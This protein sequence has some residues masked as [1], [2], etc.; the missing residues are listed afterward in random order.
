MVHDN[1]SNDDNQK[2]LARQL[3]HHQAHLLTRPLDE[4][5][6]I[7]LGCDEK[8]FVLSRY[9]GGYCVN[10]RQTQLFDQQTKEQTL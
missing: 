5:G 9:L 8:N 10:Q 7:Y 4:I 3:Q 6:V 1:D 2:G